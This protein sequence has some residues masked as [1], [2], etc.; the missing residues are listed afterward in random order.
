MK[1]AF[2]EGI[3][4]ASVGWPLFQTWNTGYRENA[5]NLEMAKNNPKV[6]CIIQKF[7]ERISKT[8]I[9]K[10]PVLLLQ[11]YTGITITA[12]KMRFGAPNV[13]ITIT[14]ISIYED[15]ILFYRSFQVLIVFSQGPVWSSG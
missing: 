8:N 15:L 7:L 11:M 2:V 10:L 1:T 13:T 14:K 3:C 4:R 9:T 12:P 5:P 6:T